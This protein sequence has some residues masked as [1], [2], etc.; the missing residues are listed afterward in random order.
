MQPFSFPWGSPFKSLP[1]LIFSPEMPHISKFRFNLSFSSPR[2]SLY[3]WT[4]LPHPYSCLSFLG[5]GRYYQ[6]FCVFSQ[7]LYGL[8]CSCY[9][10]AD[11]V[12]YT[13]YSATSKIITGGY[14]PSSLLLFIRSITAKNSERQTYCCMMTWGFD[15]EQGGQTP[16]HAAIFKLCIF[17]F[18]FLH[19]RIVFKLRGFSNSLSRFYVL[20]FI[21]EV[22]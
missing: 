6:I 1:I 22:S 16:S 19:F 11:I 10:A 13:W 20:K 21:C 2:L 15:I 12:L 14:L 5:V 3:L 17:T 8:H 18:F 7:I 9:H 4:V